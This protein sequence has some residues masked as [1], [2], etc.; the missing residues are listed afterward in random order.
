MLSQLQ[1]LNKKVND[2]DDIVLLLNKLFISAMDVDLANQIWANNAIDKVVLDTLAAAKSS[3]VLP[4]K[5]ILADW[6]F[7]DG[8]VFYQNQC[9]VPVDENLCRNIVRR[10]HDLQPMGHP[11]QFATLELVR[12]DYW[13]PGMASFV[14][15]YVLGCAMCQQAKIN[16][17]P[18]VP[19]LMPIPAKKGA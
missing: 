3:D 9:Y 18:T 16:T 12:R 5:S 2:N 17:H 15:N 14:R 10:Y 7:E 11:G 4:M 1:H 13:W 6:I 8:L 19:L